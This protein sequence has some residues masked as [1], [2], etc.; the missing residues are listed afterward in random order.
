MHQKA[1]NALNE[2]MTTPLKS[3]ENPYHGAIREF[4]EDF[5]TKI[6]VAASKLNEKIE[7]NIQN[8]EQIAKRIT[9]ANDNFNAQRAEGLKLSLQLLRDPF[10]EA[11]Q[12]HLPQIPTQQDISTL[13]VFPPDST[14]KM[15]VFKDIAGDFNDVKVED[16]VRK[17]PQNEEP[18]KF[19]MSPLDF[20][21]GVE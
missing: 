2:F 4:L 5:N 19:F 13:Y 14:I 8:V 12:E 17:I 1:N 21:D 11:K 7:T 15:D 18:R 3:L 10:I 20:F 16:L 9:A 6:S